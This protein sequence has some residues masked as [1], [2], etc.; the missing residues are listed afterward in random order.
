MWMPYTC[1]LAL[2]NEAL[3]KIDT[4]PVMKT[5]KVKEMI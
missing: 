3:W 2:Q 4:M 1:Q 5:I